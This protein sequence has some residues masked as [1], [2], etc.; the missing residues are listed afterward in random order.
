MPERR[1]DLAELSGLPTARAPHL[2]PNR[3][4]GPQVAYPGLLLCPFP[5]PIVS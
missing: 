4:Q 2:R 3:D 5:G 1:Q